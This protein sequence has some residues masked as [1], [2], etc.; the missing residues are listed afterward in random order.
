MT[1]WL[2]NRV[3]IQY[4]SQ[5]SKSS[6]QAIKQTINPSSSLFSLRICPTLALII[7][8]YWASMDNMESESKD[9]KYFARCLS[10]L[11]NR[12][13]PC[14]EIQSSETPVVGLDIIGVPMALTKTF[15]RIIK[16]I[17]I[18][19]K[20]ISHGKGRNMSRRRSNCTVEVRH[21]LISDY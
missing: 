18:A 6:K 3:I 16:I 19:A 14:L 15:I 21:T 9:A 2:A 10:C 7:Q 5:A 12:R 4:I 8:C 20:N 13:R 17:K 1:D 11:G